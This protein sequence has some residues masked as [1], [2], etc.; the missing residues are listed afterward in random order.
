MFH[1]PYDYERT[2]KILTLAS[3]NHIYMTARKGDRELYIKVSLL[4]IDVLQPKRQERQK[5]VL[6]PTP[7]SVR[8]NF[9]FTFYEIGVKILL[10]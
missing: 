7:A 5:T 1:E 10:N 2:V 4:L 8:Q 3:N 6:S 9:H